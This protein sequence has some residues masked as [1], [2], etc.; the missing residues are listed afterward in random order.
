MLGLALALV[1]GD[2]PTA[3]AQE[4]IS[5]VKLAPQDYRGRR[6]VL[7]GEVVEVRALSPRSERGVYRLVDGSDP[8]GI[9]VRTDQLPSSGGP[10]EVTARLSPELLS[11]GSLLLDEVERDGAGSSMN[12][13]AALV[14]LLGLGGAIAALAMYTRVRRDERHMHLGP[15]MWLIPTGGA[16]KPEPAT[17]QNVRFNYHLQYIQEERSDT[18]DKRK[19]QL[20][21]MLAVAGGIGAAGSGWFFMLHREDEARPSFVLMTPDIAQATPLPVDTTRHPDDTVRV[22]INPDLPPPPPPPPPSSVAVD[23]PPEPSEAPVRGLSHRDSVRLG[24]IKNPRD[25]ARTVVAVRDTVTR[26]QPPPASPPPAPPPPPPPPPPA[27]T[28]VET[29]RDTAPTPPKA[30]P[31]AMKAAATRS[32]TQGIEQFAAAVSARDVGN[33]STMFFASDA[34]RR[35]KF[36]NFLRDAGP[37]S[38]LQG[39]DAAEVTET[40]ADAAFTLMVRYRGDFGVE[41]RKAV[42]FQASTRRQGEEWTFAGVQLLENFP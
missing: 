31:E 37:T 42:R 39:T 12:A 23:P 9:L 18:L 21:G 15:P 6:I 36:V 10:F 28:P 41:K 19:R 17:G 3:A 40:A 38:A 26:I 7:S 25:T 34:K 16:D 5:K 30:D 24:L 2:L 22:G 11:E 13:I 33:V 1:L 29:P 27:P 35:D 20:L 8:A 4:T 14:A 32:L